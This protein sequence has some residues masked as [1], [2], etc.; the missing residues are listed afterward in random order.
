[1]KDLQRLYEECLAELASIGIRPMSITKVS[2][3]TRARKRW[4]QARKVRAGSLMSPEAWE[5]NV[6]ADLLAEDLPDWPAKT[7]LIHEIL[8][9]VRGCH[10]HTGR[11]RTLADKVE[12]ELGYRIKSTNK[13][14]DFG[15][16]AEPA[17]EKE[18][19]PYLVQCTRCGQLIPR[20]RMS[21]VVKYPS[22]YHCARCGGKLVRVK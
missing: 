20:Q 11:W 1:M 12:Q 18:D 19:Y 2:V 16:P 15:L 17:R 21:K 10:G 8:H 7:V 22:R 4:G 6:N 3:N 14:E 5:I 13:P 9:C